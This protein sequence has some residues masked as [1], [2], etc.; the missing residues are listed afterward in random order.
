MNVHMT[1]FVFIHRTKTPAKVRLRS[2][3]M[4]FHKRFLDLKKLSDVENVFQMQNTVMIDGDNVF[5]IQQNVFLSAPL[6]LQKR[7]E[8]KLY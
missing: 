2:Y 6:A 8:G 1:S 3:V 7:K 5:I 4:M